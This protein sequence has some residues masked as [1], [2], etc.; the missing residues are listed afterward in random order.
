MDSEVIHY[1]QRECGLLMWEI[2]K[3]NHFT[4]MHAVIFTVVGAVIWMF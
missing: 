1:H 3:L 4:C 2:G